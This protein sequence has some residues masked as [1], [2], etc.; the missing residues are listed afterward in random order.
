LGDAFL[1]EEEADHL[2][3]AALLTVLNRLAR[4]CHG[5]AIDPQSGTVL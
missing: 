1:D 3:P 4:I 5:V 2:D